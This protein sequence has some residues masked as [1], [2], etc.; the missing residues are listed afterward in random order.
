MPGEVLVLGGTGNFGRRIVEGLKRHGVPVIAAGGRKDFD[1]HRELGAR[2]DA[3]APKVVVNTCGPFQMSGYDVAEACIARRIHYIDLADGREFVKGITVL[4][5]AAKAS[6]VSIISG[7]SSV[8]GLSSAVIEHFRHEFERVD[9]IDFGISPGQQTPRGLATVTAIMT[10]V[11]KAFHGVHGWQ[12]VHRRAYP[13]LGK[14]WMANC[15]IPDLD[16]LP[17]RYGLKRVRFFAGSELGF[18]HL[19]LW[20]L[21]WLVRLGLPLNLPRRA[22][23]MLRIS[24]LFDGFGSANGGM[25]AILRGGGRERQWYLIARSGHG[26]QVPCVPAI[27]LAGKL[28]GNVGLAPGAYPCVGLV[29]LDEYMAELSGF[30]IE[31]I[32]A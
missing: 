17:A 23:L 8:P 2:L 3:L 31:Q 32:T 15:D 25:H 1:V 4:D 19:N 13:T 5:A 26:P 29:S 21:S 18:L 20:F 27:V 7:A 30:D 9:E 24:N 6:G 28:M 10:Y 22:A 11:G 16:L 14:R 12:D